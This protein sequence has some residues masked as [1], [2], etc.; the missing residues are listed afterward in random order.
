MPLYLRD[1]RDAL[2]L[3]LTAAAAKIGCHFTTLQKWEKGGRAVGAEELSRIARAYGVDEIALFFHPENR[4]AAERARRALAILRE[5][6]PTAADRWLD[7]A[8][9]MQGARASAPPKKIDA[10]AK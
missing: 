8:E 3:S 9:A 7:L 1:W 5:M 4:D 10:P 6:D 2:G